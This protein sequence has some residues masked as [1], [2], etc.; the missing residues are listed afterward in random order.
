MKTRTLPIVEIEATAGTQVRR[1]LDPK[2][3]E[4]YTEDMQ[5]GAVFPAII[6]FAEKGSERYVLADGF[7][8]LAAAKAAGRDEIACEVHEGRAHDALKYALGANDAHGFRRSNRD[9]RNAV[10]IALKDPEWSQ[11]SAT[12]VAALCRVSDNFV[13]KVREELTLSG[14]LDPQD[15]VKITRD[16]KTVERKAGR[17]SSE[18]SDE[19]DSGKKTGTSKKQTRKP[20][21]QDDIDREEV[22]TALGLINDKPYNGAVAL[23]K[24]GLHDELRTAILARE[25]LD[26]LIKAAKKAA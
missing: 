21:T 4:A 11:W 17:A 8:R 14:E 26:E 1:F 22:V 10:E 15:T 6:V 9:K 16:G 12:D 20:K 2:M 19:R 13:R 3:I 24:L 5:A 25:W 18:Y 23:D 7:H